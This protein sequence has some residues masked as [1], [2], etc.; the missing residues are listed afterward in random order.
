MGGRGILVRRGFEV[1]GDKM[2]RGGYGLGDVL[3]VDAGS[4]HKTSMVLKLLR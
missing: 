3:G 1:E 4:G 2:G